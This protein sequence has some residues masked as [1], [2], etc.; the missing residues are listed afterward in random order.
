MRKLAS[1]SAPRLVIQPFKVQPQIPVNFEG[2]SWIKLKD[3]F[4][5]VYDKTATSVSK[6]ELYQCVENLCLQNA[7]EKLYNNLKKEFQLK[8]GGNVAQLDVQV[9]VKQILWNIFYFFQSSDFSVFLRTVDSMWSD[10][11]DQVS[12]IRNI[13]LHLDRS[14]NPSFTSL[15]PDHSNNLFL[16]RTLFR[17][18]KSVLFGTCRL[19]SFANPSCNRTLCMKKSFGLF[20][21]RLRF[22]GRLLFNLIRLI[23]VRKS[24]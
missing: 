16:E 18:K 9:T 17:I 10:H 4:H 6:E 7:S 23:F 15:L 20:F 2:D 19:K 14:S 13:F 12:T 11:V 8:I 22:K 21:S 24:L 5:A 3:A 1:N